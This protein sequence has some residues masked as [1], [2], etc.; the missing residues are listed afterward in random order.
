MFT[1]QQM[2]T[3]LRRSNV[4]VELHRYFLTNKVFINLWPSLFEC[5]PESLKYGQTLRARC[6][7]SEE[8]QLTQRELDESTRIDR[9]KR[10]FI[11]ESSSY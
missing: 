3:A 7:P 2:I 9:A 4:W 5:D 11:M 6:V 1:G 10:M 8:P